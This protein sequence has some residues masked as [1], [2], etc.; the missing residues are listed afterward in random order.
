MFSGVA[1]L[2]FFHRF[3]FAFT[4]WLT[5]W[6]KRSSFWPISTFDMPSSLS[7]IISSF[8][9]KLERRGTLPS[10]WI[11]RGHCRVINWPNFNIF[12]SQGTGRLKEREIWEQPISEAVRTHATL[13]SSSYMGMVLVS[14][15]KYISNIKDHWLQITIKNI[16]IMKK[17]WNTARITI[18][19]WHRAIKS[20]NVVRKI[21]PIDLLNPRVATNFHSLRN[22]IY[23]KCNKVKPNKMRYT[24]STSREK[25][26]NQG[27]RWYM[28]MTSLGGHVVSNY[29]WVDGWIYQ[30]INTGKQKVIRW[31]GWNRV[32]YF[33]LK[34]E[35]RHLKF[36]LNIWVLQ[37]G[38]RK[39]HV[40]LEG[41]EY[42]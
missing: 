18:K 35:A 1:F 36:S 42:I 24:C 32:S 28:V 31:E 6:H 39:P 22:A 37:I 4:T 15:T 10:T 41:P 14:Q 26:E 12:L 11:L 19:T 16:V 23:V 7:L 3:S 38:Q 33:R 29:G 13:I 34:Y 9:F 27:N 5:V 30:R 21:A 8:W 20:P 2:I 40:I 25:G 17:V